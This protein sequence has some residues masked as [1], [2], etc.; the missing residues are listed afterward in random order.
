VARTGFLAAK[1]RSSGPDGLGV[2]DSAAAR[3]CHDMNHRGGPFAVVGVVLVVAVACGLDMRDEGGFGDAT[4]GADAGSAQDD[5]SGETAESSGSASDESG[6]PGTSQDASTSTGTDA[7]ASSSSTGDEGGP[8]FGSGSAFDD[9]TQMFAYINEQREGYLSH[10]RWRGMPW[11]GSGHSTMTWPTTFVWDDALATQAQA[12]ADAIAAGAAFTGS[13][14][15]DGVTPAI[16]V[17]GVDSSHYSV[18]GLELSQSW[19]VESQSS[20]SHH[21]GSAR[22]AIYYHDPGG[23]GPVLTRLGIGAADAGAGDTAWVFV[24]E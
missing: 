20:L 23:E 9:V 1:R 2:I 15:T 12:E 14:A 10:E 11:T 21:H 6:A 19:G 3:L 18:A 8:S 13:P 5:G 4:A 16:Y 17:S 7:D 22:M 24:W